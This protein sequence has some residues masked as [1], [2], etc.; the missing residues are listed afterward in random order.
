M[1]KISNV[2]RRNKQKEVSAQQVRNLIRKNAPHVT[3]ARSDS[4]PPLTKRNVAIMLDRMSLRQLAK[5]HITE[6]DLAI[7]AT[8]TIPGVYSAR[9]GR[10]DDWTMYW[11]YL[12]AY[13]YVPEVS[14]AVKVKNRML[15]KMGYEFETNVDGEAEELERK[16][17]QLKLKR[18]L[19][20][21]TK[22]CFIFGN[23]YAES[24][25]NSESTFLPD[26]TLKNFKP[27]TEF[28][29]LKVLDP[30]TMQCH[31]DRQKFD[32]QRASP[33]VLRYAQ[34][35]LAPDETPDVFKL[36]KSDNVVNLAADQVFHLKFNCIVSA[37][38]GSSLIRE[39][40]YALKAYIIMLQY[41]PAIVEKRA[42]PP[43]HVKTG[44]QSVYGD[45]GQQ[46]TYLPSDED[47]ETVKSNFAARG[48]TEDYYSDILTTIE[49]V[50]K[51]A[52]SLAGI[53]E[54][55]QA[56]KERVLVGLGIPASLFDIVKTGSQVKWGELKFSVLVDDV[57]EC[58]EDLEDLVNT[59]LMPMLTNSGAEWHMKP[60]TP[61][62]WQAI[63]TPLI[64]L[65][66]ARIVSKEYCLERLDL[67]ESAGEGTMY[68][69]NGK[70]DI[71]IKQPKN[72][73][74]SNDNNDSENNGGEEE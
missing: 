37:I 67:P 73:P 74:K 33:L 12:D 71:Y 53:Q 1:E 68:E 60:P 69:L 61:E 31:V 9:Y 10:P 27:A 43:L 8:G 38:F 26:N 16:W 62:D 35:K 50:Y 19:K 36:S 30:R 4:L 56:W 34:V 55:I 58:Q 72:E 64:Q 5:G 21:M 6:S 59:Q 24:V 57:M 13:L 39:T 14:F 20:L 54:Y 23:G 32:V 28:Y 17:K 48:A 51:S 29:G 15:W 45:A 47:V 52:G 70:P 18:N 65:Y 25:D 63:V 3:L 42:Y 11:E 41:L 46:R 44:M 40:I 7:A 49:E 22:N 2:F 66:E